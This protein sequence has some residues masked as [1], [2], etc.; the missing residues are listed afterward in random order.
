MKTNCKAIMR[1]ERGHALDDGTV[2]SRMTSNTVDVRQGLVAAVGERWIVFSDT[3]A[4]ALAASYTLNYNRDVS[5]DSS[6]PNARADYDNVIENVPGS[7]LSADPL[8]EANL[9]IGYIF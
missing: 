7:K 3:V 1:N 6:D 2:P 8:P 9:T 4:I 5:V